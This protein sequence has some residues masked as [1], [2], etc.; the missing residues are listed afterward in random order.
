M[1]KQ[2]KIAIVY[3]WSPPFVFTAF[4]ES[5]LNIQ[6]PRDCQ[7]RWFRGVGWCH[8]RRRTDGCEQAIDWGADLICSL[9]ADQAYEPDIVSRLLARHDEGCDVIAAMVPQ[10]GYVA[11]CGMKPFSRLAWNLCYDENGQ[12]AGVEAIDPTA[13]DLQQVDLPTTAAMMFPTHLLDKLPR[14]WYFEK[15]D[16]KTW[17]R[18]EA[19]DSRFMIRLTRETGAKA[20]VDTT[21]KVQHANVFKID[22]SFQARFSDWEQEGAGD[23][24]ICS[25]ET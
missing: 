11:G 18:T 6:A 16:R 8:S 7:I 24:E 10:R 4:T 14:P 20:W 12:Q 23:P 13:G 2:R 21:I 17:K 19:E 1:T 3:A 5:A 15:F 25:Y 9:D 22:D